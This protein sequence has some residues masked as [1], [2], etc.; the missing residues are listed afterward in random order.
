MGSSPPYLPVITYSWAQKDRKVLHSIQLHEAQRISEQAYRG[1]HN[2]QYN[3][4]FSCSNIGS[5][6]NPKIKTELSLL[7]AK[8]LRALSEAAVSAIEFSDV[9]KK[10]FLHI[11]LFG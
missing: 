2:A 5:Y 9:L 6:I 11:L 7:I 4:K 1:K 8:N 3:L 10:T